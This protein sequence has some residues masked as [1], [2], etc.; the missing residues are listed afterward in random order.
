MG[1]AGKNVMWAGFL[2]ALPLVAGQLPPVSHLYSA[3]KNRVVMVVAYIGPGGLLH[4]KHRPEVR[5]N[6]QFS[7]KQAPPPTQNIGG[8]SRISDL[9][10]LST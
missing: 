9:G 5:N 8:W 4:A 7:A 3:A 2:A 6:A 10:G 1:G